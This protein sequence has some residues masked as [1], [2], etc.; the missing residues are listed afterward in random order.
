MKT[1]LPTY[2]RQVTL[3]GMTETGL[4]AVIDYLY[5]SNLMVNLDVVQD[6]VSAASYLQVVVVVSHCML[7]I[8]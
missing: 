4:R 6:V 7:Q 3:E 5:T 1:S 8:H 2:L